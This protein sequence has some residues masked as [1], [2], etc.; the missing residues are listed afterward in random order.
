VRTVQRLLG[1]RVHR[2]LRYEDLVKLR[3]PVRKVAP[4]VATIDHRPRVDSES[5][6]LRHLDTTPRQADLFGH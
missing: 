1:M 4:F 5:G 3:V 6:A 2:K